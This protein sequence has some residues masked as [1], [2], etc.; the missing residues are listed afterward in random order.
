MASNSALSQTIQ[1]LTL[2]KIREL[3]K[4]RNAYESRKA[5][6]LDGAKN[7]PDQHKR[8]NHLL[9]GTKELDPGASRDVTIGHIERWL[10]QAR[11]DSSIPADMLQRFEKTLMAKLDARSRK[12]TLADLYSR[13]L[14]EWMNPPSST[15]GDDSADEEDFLVV[16]ERQK[17]R[18]RQLC[19]QFEAAVF[20]PFETSEANIHTFLEDLFPAEEQQAALD[21]IRRKVKNECDSLWETEA[22]F[23]HTSLSR[24]IQGLLMEELLSDAKRTVLKGFLENKVAMTEIA[25]VLNMRYAD[26]KNWDW[27]AGEDGIPVL[28]RQQTNGKYRIWVDEDVLQTIFAEFVAVKFCNILKSTFKSTLLGSD[29][30]W[31]LTQSPVRMER[32]NLRRKY[33]LTEI[34]RQHNVEKLRMEEYRDTYFLSHMPISDTALFEGRPS[35]DDASDDEDEKPDRQTGPKRNI[36]QEIL[37][38][39]ATETLFHQ[40][41]HG[42]AAVIQSDMKWYA[43]G[44]PHSTLFAI[45]TFVGF[46]SDWINFFTKY[47][48]APLNMDRSCDGRT[49]MGPRIRQRGV[50]LAGAMEKM[51]GE[52]VLFFMDLTVNRESGMLLYRIH[53]DLWLCGNPAKC[54]LAWEAMQKFAKVTGLEFNHSKTGSVY[55]AKPKDAGIASRL[56]NGPVTIGFLTLDPESGNWVIDQEKVEEHVQQLKKQLDRCDS[57]ISWIRTWNSCIGRFFTNNFGQPA[58]CFGRDHVDLILSTYQKMQN[59]LFNDNG[60][61][62]TVT[63]HLRKMI[64]TRFRITNVP[65][66][67]F[68]FPQQ[69]GGLGLRNPF[70]STLLV[71]DDLEST[72]VQLMD[73][74]KESER[75]AYLEAK[76]TFDDMNERERRRRYAAVHPDSESKVDPVIS[77]TEMTAFMSFEEFTRFRESS[78]SALATLY[79]KLMEVPD[80]MDVELT[81]EVSGALRKVSS[82]M[83]FP[84][85]DNELK[86]ILQLY[87]EEPLKLLGGL[88]LVDKRF[89]PVGVLAMVKG[90]RVTWQMV[91]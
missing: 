36:K 37:R 50:P 69:L 81:K 16:E 84:W 39:V 20:R 89:L 18:L 7:S 14:T 59:T 74:Y 61:S 8:L 27:H 80:E 73:E 12:L 21:Q 64:E 22:P 35:Y 44:L 6:I 66:A 15:D 32:D 31:K 29:G 86:W 28:P 26:L 42:E 24:C 11:Y 52:L 40:H 71:R 43:T 56:P 78:D 79:K 53:D 34:F 23:N 17:Q 1:A 49:P 10:D 46:S 85:E 47:L 58:Y 33:Y 3:E 9:A 70:I 51:M 76:K 60:R 13:L 65:D 75:K 41:L 82:Q 77:K 25:D 57:V 88:S 67:F 45:M 91:L 87:A 30:V 19:D 2:S 4:L 83:E 38:H 62:S 72:P 63:E 68:F 48:Q 90:K 5:E 54:A 55:L